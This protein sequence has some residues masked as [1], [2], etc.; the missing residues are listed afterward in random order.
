MYAFRNC[1]NWFG[2]LQFIEDYVADIF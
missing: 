1:E 2:F